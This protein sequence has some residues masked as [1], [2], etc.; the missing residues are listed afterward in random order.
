MIRSRSIHKNIYEI[1]ALGADSSKFF[2]SCIVSPYIVSPGSW[3]SL[4]LMLNAAK[5]SDAVLSSLRKKNVQR[6]IN[7]LRPQELIASSLRI[8]FE[9]SMIH[10]F[11]VYWLLS[12]IQENPNICLRGPPG[13]PGRN[14]INGLNG[15]SG[16]DGRNGTKGEKGVAGPQG[17]RGEKGD[18]GINGTDADHRNWKQCVWKSEDSRDIGLLKVR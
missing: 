12:E 15:L 11:T 14:G 13:L 9:E 18:A 7:V 2:A 17:P 10:V 6:F 8:I 5:S 1:K 4:D 16:C 3:L